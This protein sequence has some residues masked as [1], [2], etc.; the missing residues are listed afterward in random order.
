MRRFLVLVPSAVRALAAIVLVLGLAGSSRADLISGLAVYYQF[1]GSGAD[2]SGNGRDLSLFGGVGFAPGL[3]GQAL[4]LHH[5]NSQYAQRPV[6]DPV[7]NFGAGDFTI[8][9]WVNFNALDGEQTLIEKF[10]GGSGPGWTL[11]KL[12]DNQLRFATG[13]APGGVLNSSTVNITT[14]T[15]HDIIVRR[16]GTSFDLFF[17]GVDAVSASNSSP[18]DTTTNPLLIGRRDAADGRDF[19]VDGRLDENAIWTRALDGSEI[20]ELYNN[21]QGMELPIGSVPEPHTL[22][23]LG[24]GAFSLLALGYRRRRSC[25]SRRES[26]RAGK[27]RRSCPTASPHARP[28][29]QPRCRDVSSIDGS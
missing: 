20:A 6:D 27:T 8:Q 25:R 5:N 2:S 10:A 13:F 9:T 29:R 4:D 28:S 3:F 16:S 23:L 14:G 19:S 12:S 21:G 22:T 24:T 15:W 11:T 26:C 1:D 17:D 18:I 7:L